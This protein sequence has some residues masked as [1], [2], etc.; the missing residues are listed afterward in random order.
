MNESRSSRNFA[1]FVALVGILCG[2]KKVATD[3]EV[4]RVFEPQSCSFRCFAC[5]NGCTFSRC[6]QRLLVVWLLKGCDGAYE[7]ASWRHVNWTFA[8]IVSR[9]SRENRPL[10]NIGDPEFGNNALNGRYWSG[11]AG[12]SWVSSSGSTGGGDSEESLILMTAT[13]SI[14]IEGKCQ[15]LHHSIY[16]VNVKY[17]A[18]WQFSR[19]LGKYSNSIRILLGIQRTTLNSV[20]FE[21][22]IR[23]LFRANT[24]CATLNCVVEL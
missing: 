21:Y 22:P 2:L 20:V 3:D 14:T 7:Q 1:V 18:P 9:I 24:I 6:F 13:M 12:N 4:D 16:S 15:K 10:L 23:I 17:P 5:P 11:R 19:S 8:G